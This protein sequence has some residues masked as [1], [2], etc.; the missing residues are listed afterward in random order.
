MIKFKSIEGGTI[1]LLGAICKSCHRRK[2]FLDNQFHSC[3]S[4]Y[5]HSNPP[6]E[7]IVEIRWREKK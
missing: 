1:Y 2:F 5:R 3:K 6:K 7:E 4:C